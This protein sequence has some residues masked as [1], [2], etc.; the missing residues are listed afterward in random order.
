[1]KLMTPDNSVSNNLPPFLTN[2]S[3]QN[4]ISLWLTFEYVILFIALYASTIS[5]AG[6][7]SHAIDQF[8]PDSTNLTNIIYQSE[9]ERGMLRGYIATIIVF[10][11][12]FSLLFL[13]LKK[14]ELANPQL[15][16]IKAR[17]MCIYITLI[18]TFLIT[19]ANITSTLYGF[20]AG[21]TTSN[22]LLHFIASLFISGGVFVYY[23]WQ[24]K[25]DRKINA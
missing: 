4:H 8:I 1:M 20:L 21:T 10:Y 19:A 18:V 6:I 3:S 15:K 9:F 7:T 5:L 12:V 13:H 11:P 17:K 16:S 23:L 22:S 2:S 14:L 24:V 25:D